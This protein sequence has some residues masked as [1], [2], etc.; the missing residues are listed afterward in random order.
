[1]KK[2]QEQTMRT[3]GLATVGFAALLVAAPDW[4]RGGLL[5]FAAIFGALVYV[6]DAN[7]RSW[8]PDHRRSSGVRDDTA[9]R[10]SGVRDDTGRRNSGVRDDATTAG[11]KSPAGHRA[12]I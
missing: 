2:M 9:R 4:A 7:V 3:L 6:L 11:G 10:N 12:A 8:I 5:V 1:M